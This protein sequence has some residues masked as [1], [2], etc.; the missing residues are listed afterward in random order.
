[1]THI[2][3]YMIEACYN[4]FELTVMHPKGKLYVSDIQLS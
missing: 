2:E 3:N 4:E 1:M